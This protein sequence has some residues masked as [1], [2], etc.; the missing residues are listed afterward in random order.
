MMVGQL[1]PL[2]PQYQQKVGAVQQ[3]FEQR[4]G[5]PD[6]LAH[7]RRL[8]LPHVA[9]AVRLLVVYEFVL[10]RGLPLRAVRFVRSDF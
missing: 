2:N 3:I 7:A 9:A 6:A 4:F 10:P 5:P 1:S 8:A